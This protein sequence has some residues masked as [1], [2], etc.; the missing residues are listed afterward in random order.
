M[1]INSCGMFTDRQTGE[2]SGGV[3]N[4]ARFAQEVVNKVAKKVCRERTAILGII[5]V[6]FGSC[7]LLFFWHR[8]QECW[9]SHSQT[10]SWIHN[11]RQSFVYPL[12]QEWDMIWKQSRPRGC[13][14]D[15]LISTSPLC[16][17]FSWVQRCRHN[18]QTWTHAPYQSQ[19][20][21]HDNKMWY[22]PKQATS[23][24]VKLEKQNAVYR[25]GDYNV[26]VIEFQNFSNS[27]QL[28]LT[29]SS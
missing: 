27:P 17:S 7:L 5:L 26:P 15:Y 11:T 9:W 2:N 25:W 3:E 4:R 6:R 19:I 12:N 14:L 24:G 20:R 21:E 1:S 8:L 28:S 29:S 10:V 22:H 16:H 18:E 23:R 13:L